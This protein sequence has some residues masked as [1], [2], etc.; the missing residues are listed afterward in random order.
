[1]ATTHRPRL[2]TAPVLAAMSLAVA[3][4]TCGSQPAIRC[5][6]QT[7]ASNDAI[8][9]FTPVGAPRV[10]P[11]AAAGS[12]DALIASRGLPGYP[13]ATADP[14]G[15]NPVLLRLGL[16][17]FAPSPTDPG[18]STTPS[19][20][21]LKTEWI[22]DLIQDAQVNAAT[23][24]RLSAVQ[25]A[26]LAKYPYVTTEPPRP[27]PDDSGRF[28]RPYSFGTFDSVYPDDSG[29]C[30]ATLAPSDLA[31]PDVPAHRVVVPIPG[32]GSY[33]SANADGTPGMQADAPATH[34]RYDWANFRVVVSPESLG[35]EA[36]ADLTVTRDGCQADYHVSILSPRVPC[37]ALDDS[38]NPILPGRGDA[39]LCVSAA[40]ATNPYGSGIEPS[41]PVRCEQVGF[42]PMAP[43]F[44]CMPT[45]TSP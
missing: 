30:H 39:S 4:N 8:G 19:S 12:C 13:A 22:G 3:Q 25:Q 28:D 37:T 17:S 41:I 7:S 27:P 9:R 24:P 36:F 15:P 43:D 16:E 32:D 38:G 26:G 1:M 14:M 20:L 42:D 21:A 40:T 29:V 23:D 2:R 6:V 34:V 31:Y 5:V 44:E 45:K 11:G 18:Q 35:V 10:T 33:A